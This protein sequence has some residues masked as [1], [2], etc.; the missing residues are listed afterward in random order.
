MKD[1]IKIIF[2]CYHYLKRN[3][4]FRRIWGHDFS[5]FKEHIKFYKKKYP[6]IDPDIFFD[7]TEG[8]DV[9]LPPKCSVITFDDSLKVQSEVIAPYLERNKIKAIF[10]ISPCIFS[11]EPLNAQIVHF[12]MA[13]YGIRNFVDQVKSKLSV[14]NKS[15]QDIEVF[16]RY[17]QD[18]YK[19]S[20]M[21]KKFLF[22]KLAQEES[23]KI[24]LSVWGDYMKKEMPDVFSKIHMS[25]KD[26]INLSRRGHTIGLH[27][28]SHSLINDDT[29]DSKL[30]KEELAGSKK[31]LEEVL[32]DKI[33]SFSYPYGFR[34]DI[35]H[36]EKN[37]CRLNKIG[38]KYLFTIYNNSEFN[39]N[40][41]G[42]YSS[43][44]SDNI[45]ILKNKIWEYEISNN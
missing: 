11:G 5:L 43:Q 7:F 18:V 25:K 16:S 9:N 28:Y 37:I 45:D 27:S 29:F 38:L 13:Y 8:K 32:A 41:I 31:Y 14:I 23:R 22:F 19:L 20:E 40:F 6:P 39:K 4:E 30:F 17:F 35:L 36:K 33:V 24:L 34:K 42:R 21:L 3:D 15:F 12:S 2:I 26:V 1:K 10:N 44:S